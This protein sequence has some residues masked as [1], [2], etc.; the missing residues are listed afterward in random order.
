M[1]DYTAKLAWT[2]RD[3]DQDCDVHH[4]K[5][6]RDSDGVVI[7]EHVEFGGCAYSGGY[8]KLW[9]TCDLSRT[10]TDPFAGFFPRP[11]LGNTQCLNTEFQLSQSDTTKTTLQP[12]KSLPVAT[13]QP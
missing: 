7:G 11:S 10:L 9:G 8:R 12:T 1:R 4:F 3:K 5:T 2:T 13:Q 6:V